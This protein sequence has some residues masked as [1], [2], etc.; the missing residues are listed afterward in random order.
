MSP[1]GRVT[2]AIVGEDEVHR[3]LAMAL[4]DGVLAAAAGARGA[5]WLDP[6]HVRE[7]VVVPEGQDQPGRRFYNS[8]WDHPLPVH[9]RRRPPS[10]G[11]RAGRPLAPGASRLRHLYQLHALQPEPPDLLVILQDTDGNLE[12]CLAGDDL[13]RMVQDSFHDGP[14]VV[15]GFPHRDAEAWLMAA[16]I[17]PDGESAQRLDA[18]RVALSFDPAKQPERLTSSPN[19]AVTDAKRVLRFVVLQEGERLAQGTP[20]SVPPSPTEADELACRLA[21]HLDRA[22]A[23]QACNLAGFVLDLD[24]AV[25]TVFRDFIPGTPV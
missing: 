13:R 7:W 14:A 23:Y 15:V 4:M 8:H 17:L 5:D 16:P 12:L 19:D 10:F 1:D 6:H 11:R 22:R 20:G 3:A 2:I 25:V 9:G 18:A 21:Q 24:A